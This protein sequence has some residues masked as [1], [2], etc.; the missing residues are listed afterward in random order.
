[1]RKVY[2]TEII[3]G[4]YLCDKLHQLT[5]NLDELD[6]VQD[7]YIKLKSGK[8]ILHFAAPHECSGRET[9]I[10]EFEPC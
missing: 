2:P 7:D 10:I 6:F 5:Q 8:T 9:A 3:A 4:N 1:V